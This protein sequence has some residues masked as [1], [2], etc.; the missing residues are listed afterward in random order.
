MAQTP[1]FRSEALNARQ[2]KWLGE[3]LLIRPFGYRALTLAAALIAVII[4]AF[5]ILGSYTRR[6]AVSGELVPNTGMVKVYAPQAGVIRKSN[7]VEGQTVKRGDVL[8]VVSSERHTARYGSVE[9]TVSGQVEARRGSIVEEVAQTR[10]MQDQERLTQ[11][12]RV[13]GLAAERAKLDSQIDGQKDRVALAEQTLKRYQ[14][15]LDKDYI[16]RDEVQKREELLLDQ[17]AQLQNLERDRINVQRDL[18][19]QKNELASQ[20]YKQ[21]TQL[22]QLQ[23]G[24]TNLDQELTETEGKRVLQVQ[25]PEDGVVTAVVGEVGQIADPGRSLLAIVPKGSYLVAQLYAPSRSIGFVKPGDSVLLRYQAYPYQK[26][27]HHK[28]RVLSISRTALPAAEI[29][30]LSAG[31]NSQSEPMYR[32]TVSLDGQGVTAYGKQLPLQAGMLL[33]AD[34]LQ[35]TRHLYEWVLEPLY[36]LTGKL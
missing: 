27:G 7:A 30:N 13:T 9:A 19:T 4:V 2:T 23:R 3:I 16:A 33:D 34:I 12:S 35:D 29:S 18:A 25:A 5:M 36:S 10:R 8:Y 26:F 14:G 21:Q 31:S 32:I 6:T 24:L 20:R 17:R 11:E 15:L 22:T 1:L 28:G